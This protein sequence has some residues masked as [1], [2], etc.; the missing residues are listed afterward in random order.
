MS[1]KTFA[2]NEGVRESDSKL[3]IGLIATRSIRQQAV[4]V[5]TS[6]TKIPTTP[7]SNR[8][9]LLIENESANVVYLGDSTVTTAN[10]FP[11]YP[12]QTMQINIEDDIDIY[13]I[14]SGS[15][16]IRVLEGA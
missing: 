8:R 15:S 9:T 5:A 6:A 10:G 4:T 7:L 13:G 11:I 12:R 16:A 3:W 14:A 2:P 1:R